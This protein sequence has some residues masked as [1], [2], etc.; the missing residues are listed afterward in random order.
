MRPERAASWGLGIRWLRCRDRRPCRRLRPNPVSASGEILI[1]DR[2]VND[3]P[4]RDRDLAMVFQNYALYPHMIVAENIGYPLKI[5]KLPKAKRTK[6]VQSA[7][8]PHG[9]SLV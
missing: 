2:R 7:T 5:A 4:V 8:V 9:R 6:R 1:G 3:I